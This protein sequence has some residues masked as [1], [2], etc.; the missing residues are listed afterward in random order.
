MVDYDVI[1]GMN[2]LSKYN[3]TI[4]CRRKKVV[5]QPSEG[6]MFEYKGIPQGS[7]WPIVST[8]KASKMLFKG[9]VGYLVSIVDTTKKVVTELSEVRVVCRFPNVFPEELPGLPPD[10][11][12]EFEIELLLGMVPI[13]KAPYRMAPIELKELKQQLQELRDKKFIRPSNLLWGAPVLFVKM[14]DGSMRMCID[15][16]DLNKVKIKNK[17]LLPRIDDLFDQLKCATVFSKID[18][19]SGYYQLKVHENDIP[20]T[21]FRTWYGHYEFLAMSFG[22]TNAPATFMDLMSGVF[23]EN[24]DKLLLSLLMISWCTHALWRSMSCI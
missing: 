19:H 18:L 15:Y 2:W 14:K 8:M 23:E 4:L 3:A 20:K 11:E 9:C 24:L 22:L 13:S 21:A 7:K 12:I 1:L 5:F 16:R 6:E 17:Y 10:Q